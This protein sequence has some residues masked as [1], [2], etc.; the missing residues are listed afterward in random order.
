MRWLRDGRF[1]RWRSLGG[2]GDGWKQRGS[3]CNYLGRVISLLGEKSS[4]GGALYFTEHAG[5]Q[6]K[7]VLGT[8][9]TKSIRVRCIYILGRRSKVDKMVLDARYFLIGSLLYSIVCVYIYIY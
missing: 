5:C 2:R 1:G 7:N 9:L 6:E 4:G 8:Q 3:A